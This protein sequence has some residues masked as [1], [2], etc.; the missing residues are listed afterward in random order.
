MDQIK[1]DSASHADINVRA[2]LCCHRKRSCSPFRSIFCVVPRHSGGWSTPVGSTL[3]RR[4]NDPIG[5]H[6]PII[7]RPFIGIRAG[8]CYTCKAH[9]LFEP[10]LPLHSLISRFLSCEPL[11]LLAVFCT[12]VTRIL[13]NANRPGVLLDCGKDIPASFCLLRL[14]Y[15]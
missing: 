5:M 13:E 7:I 6:R 2:L 10:A 15:H 14:A 12:S 3:R 11:Y 1:F 4:R 8:C 9:S